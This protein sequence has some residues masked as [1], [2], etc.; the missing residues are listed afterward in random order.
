MNRRFLIATSIV[1]GSFTGWQWN[2]M[3]TYWERLDRKLLMIEPEIRHRGGGAALSPVVKSTYRDRVV[4]TVGI[5]A[6]SPTSYLIDL[7]SLLDASGS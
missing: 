5:V 4:T 7:K 1:G 2:D 6:S 3:M